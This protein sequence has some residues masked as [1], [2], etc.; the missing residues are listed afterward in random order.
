M[1]SRRLLACLE[2]FADLKLE[3]VAAD[4]LSTSDMG[5]LIQGLDKPLGGCM[6]LA[7]VL[8]DRLFTVQTKES[9]EAAYVPKTGAFRTLESVTS[10]NE[11]DFVI[12][13]SSVSGMFGNAGQT[14]YAR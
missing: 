12:S 4:A 2:S 9:F 3:L 8:V 6:F 5:N 14:N 10:L 7:V 11:L 1:L 13:F